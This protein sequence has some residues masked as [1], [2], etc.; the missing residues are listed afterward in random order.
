MRTILLASEPDAMQ[1]CFFFYFIVVLHSFASPGH[2]AGD[3]PISV[4]PSP[5]EVVVPSSSAADVP[6]AAGL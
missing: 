3:E 2:E 4:A 5:A 1:D 6:D